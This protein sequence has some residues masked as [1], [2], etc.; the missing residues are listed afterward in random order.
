MFLNVHKILFN[1]LMYL[2]HVDTYRLDGTILAVAENGSIILA[3]TTN[4]CYIWFK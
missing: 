2:V 1:T 4:N 3:N